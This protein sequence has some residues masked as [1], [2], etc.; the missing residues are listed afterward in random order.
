[1]RASRR[2]TGLAGALVLLA[3]LWA[4]PLL[5][6]DDAIVL[7]E[8]RIEIDLQGRDPSGLRIMIGDALGGDF[9]SFE[10]GQAIV[11]V[12]FPESSDPFTVS[13]TDGESGGSVFEQRYRMAPYQPLDRVEV[14]YYG[15]I[16]PYGTF[17]ADIEP[18]RPPDMFDSF[19]G[20]SDAV[21]GGSLELGIDDWSVSLR[22]EGLHT[23]QD[24]KQ[25]R[26][27]GGR[28]DISD[29]LGALD[30]RGD[31]IQA[32]MEF[33]DA[34]LEGN[35]PLFNEGFSTRGFS[36]QVFLFDERIKITGGYSYG[37]DIAG[38]RNLAGIDDPK[39]NRAAGSIDLTLW[40]DDYVSLT[41]RG[42]YYQ[43][44]RPE[45][46]GFFDGGTAVGERAEIWGTGATLGLFDERIVVSTDFAWSN[47]ANPSDFNLGVT[48]FVTFDVIEVD[49]EED[50]A[51]RHRID[52]R[53]W[54]GERLQID[55]FG[56]YSRIGPFYR[57]VE[58]YVA[59]DRR[60]YLAG[61][62]LS[63]DP[64]TIGIER[65][66][67]DTNIEGFRGAQKT[68]E[69]TE[70]G[71]VELDLED[72]RDG[73]GEPENGETCLACQ[74]I[75]SNIS[76]EVERWQVKGTNG[77]ELIQTPGLFF[78][79]SSIINESTE[80]YSLVMD[81]DFDPF[82]TS[83]EFFHAYD[84]DESI[85]NGDRDSREHSVGVGASYYGGFWSIS[86]NG[87]GA[88]VEHLDIADEAVDYE[89]SADAD[90]SISLD[91][92]PDFNARGDIAWFRTK[93]DDDNDDS[94]ELRYSAQASLD[95]SKFL[96]DV[97]PWIDS[98]LTSTFLYQWETNKTFF[99]GTTHNI[100]M[101]WTVNFGVEF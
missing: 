69:I 18:D 62:T 20:D 63:F 81:W 3:L 93:A 79:P 41:T 77:Q 23:T 49:S 7:E 67:F 12:P 84:N 15:H 26:D 59:P 100:E 45:E 33:G 92:L 64:I 86:A 46:L 82:S 73:F 28:A 5:A 25:F 35:S 98:Y 95:F 50:N 11:T 47:Y 51:E 34:Y 85:G 1:M 99:F 4:G 91:D 78:S 94:R 56:E 89:A 19:R 24:F 27:D 60:T 17:F 31:Q 6:D 36:G 22:A 37:N 44:E 43:V 10:G 39:N 21:A 16:D 70:L 48:N 57:S 72:Y 80:T 29:I 74:A 32:H 65:E 55:V 68:H 97:A 52:A 8:P 96:P 42:S 58:T 2:P 38:A 87:F 90:F 83:L 54:D 76:F 13:L 88:V 40:R 75:P 101:S 71:R 14:D 66:S 53:V 30:Y 61:A 9:V